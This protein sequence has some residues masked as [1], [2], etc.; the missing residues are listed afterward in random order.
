MKT[1]WRAALHDIRAPRHATWLELFYDL[2]FV[3]AVAK[4]THGFA[5][6]VTLGGAAEFLALFL[7][8]WWA[9]V[10]HT[11]Y[12]TRFDTDDAGHRL[13]TL[14]QMFGAAALA[15]V[16]DDAFG[17]SSRAFALSY[18][19]IRILLLASYVNSHRQIR[20]VRP[21]TTVYLIGF[22][23]GASL[24]LISAA[25][26]EPIRFVLW[27][28]GILIDLATPWVGRR[29]L[30]AAP[31]HVEHLPERFGLFTIIVLGESVLAVVTA[32]AGIEWRGMTLATAGAGFAV[33]AGSWWFYFAHQ[34][35]W[36]GGG[37]L[38]A[39]QRYIY[40]HLPIVVGISVTGV[41]VQL[42]IPMATAP[43]PPESLWLICGGLALYTLSI[44]VI[45]RTAVRAQAA[46]WPA[47]LAFALAAAFAALGG[48]G[49]VIPAI[50]LLGVAALLLIAG[51]VMIE[52]QGAGEADA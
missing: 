50:A 26:P 15:V 5:H 41:G 30:A 14:G 16:L 47:W 40:G 22:G 17:E 51:G 10:G 3:V 46:G 19:A 49:P 43:A 4:V 35:T 13:L 11:I 31:V 1:P 45:H 18:A 25:T 6:H 23:I 44:G 7:V 48:A 27:A 2:V 20:E 29:V 24:W 21:V 39:G 34:R 38:G 52:R 32:I 33:A 12:M 28:A 9:W 42:A 37:C 8:V 36:S